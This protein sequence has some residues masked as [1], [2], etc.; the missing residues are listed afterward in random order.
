MKPGRLHVL[1]MHVSTRCDQTCGHCSIW[2]PRGD[3]AEWG[4]DERLSLLREA[5]DLG[6]RSVLFTGGEP[7][8][9][10]HIETLARSARGLGMSVQIATTGL[11]LGRSRAWLGDAVDEVYV[12]FEGP[13]SIHDGIRGPRMF[14]RLMAAIADLRTLSRRPLLVA[15]SVVSRRNAVVLE[16]TVRAARSLGFDRI[17]F[18]AIDTLSPA[19]GGAP[20]ERQSWRPEDSDVTALKRSIERLAAAGELGAFVC[21]DA[22]ALEALVAQLEA[23]PG[24]RALRRCNAPEWSSV[25]EADGT[26]RPCFFQPGIGIAKAGLG[27]ARES[28]GYAAALKHLGPGNALCASCVCPKYRPS[29]LSSLRER[30]SQTLGQALPFFRERTTAA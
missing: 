7:L 9:C 26:V 17:S 20:A 29:G 6:A 2:R 21:E 23:T 15:R 28:R 3:T 24:E 4:V 5:Q 14:E 30:V 12:S 25:V 16:D 27:A 13:E 8:L 1:V 10:D 22:R 18:L 11:G 19:F